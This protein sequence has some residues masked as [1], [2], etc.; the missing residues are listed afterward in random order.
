MAAWG[1]HLICK[2]VKS[3]QSP[4]LP[5]SPFYLEFCLHPKNTPSKSFEF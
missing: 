1:S 5:S 3:K 4:L 2:K